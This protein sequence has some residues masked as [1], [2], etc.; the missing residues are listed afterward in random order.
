MLVRFILRGMLSTLLAYFRKGNTVGN[1][2][3]I[4]YGGFWDVPLEFVVSHAGKQFLF[5]REF[6]EA[7]D[8]YP[9]NYRVFLLPGIPN[10]EIK[11]LWSDIER[12]AIEFLGE[13]PVKEVKFDK[14][15]RKRI[16][17]NVLQ[18]FVTSSR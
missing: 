5:L 15:T 4:I 11:Q 13:V 17:T 1:S 6:D 3:K 7:I 16:D 8:D 2:A 14:S 10:C 12:Q 18:R 9:D